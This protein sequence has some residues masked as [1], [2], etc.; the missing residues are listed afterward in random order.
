ML[1][2]NHFDTEDPDPQPTH[3]PTDSHRR[4]ARP[5]R[6]SATDSPLLSRKGSI[7]RESDLRR[8]DQRRGTEPA[9]RI[10]EYGKEI[11]DLDGAELILFN[12]SLQLIPR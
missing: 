5:P 9:E 2:P 7:T 1:C 10:V 6:K 11:A 8:A 12:S 3:T 4:S